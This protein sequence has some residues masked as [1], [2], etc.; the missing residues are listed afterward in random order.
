MWFILQVLKHSPGLHN[1]VSFL[2]DPVMLTILHTFDIINHPDSVKTGSLD[3][4]SI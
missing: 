2:D 4:K 1:V 3:G